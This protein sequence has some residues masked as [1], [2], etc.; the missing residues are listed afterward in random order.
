MSRRPLVNAIAPPLRPER[1]AGRTHDRRGS[2]LCRVVPLLP[3]RVEVLRPRGRA[4]QLAS[5]PA[6]AHNTPDHGRFPGRAPAP[7]T[8]D[9]LPARR[10]PRRGPPPR[11]AARRRQRPLPQGRGLLRGGE[12]PPLARLPPA[13]AEVVEPV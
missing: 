3:P 13:G 2:Y 1:H 6:P 4:A 5:A 12:G 8:D 7:C 10:L 11:G 9:E